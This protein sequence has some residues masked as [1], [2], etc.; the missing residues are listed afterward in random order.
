MFFLAA[1]GRCG[2][3]VLSEARPPS[4]VLQANRLLAAPSFSDHGGS[5]RPGLDDESSDP[6]RLPDYDG[7]VLRTFCGRTAS[8]GQSAGEVLRDELEFLGRIV[9]RDFV[10]EVAAAS[11]AEEDT[12][13]GRLPLKVLPE[14]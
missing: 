1:D 5:A 2:L 12:P 13:S 8:G 3:Q 10:A 14:S 6:F 11:L 9:G 4:L 7:F